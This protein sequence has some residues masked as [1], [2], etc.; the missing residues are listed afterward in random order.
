MTYERAESRRPPTH[1][2]YVVKM[3]L[4]ELGMSVTEAAE[5]LGVARPTPSQ[6]VNANKS[7]SPSMALKLGRFFGN[8]TELWLNMQTAYDRW[9][10]EHD[11]EELRDAAQVEP[12]HAQSS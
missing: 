1:P 6:L 12:V 8:G 5:R 7:I 10:V 2:G 11:P 9:E 3:E 4:E